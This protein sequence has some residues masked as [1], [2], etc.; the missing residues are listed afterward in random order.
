VAVELVIGLNN[1]FDGQVKKK[2]AVVIFTGLNEFDREIQVF[3]GTL[4]PGLNGFGFGH[5]DI[6]SGGGRSGEIDVKRG[7]E[8]GE[9][10]VGDYFSALGGGMN[11]I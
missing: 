3:L 7:L 2:Q 5:G 9:E 4:F 11:S 10:V 6:I 8:G 1:F